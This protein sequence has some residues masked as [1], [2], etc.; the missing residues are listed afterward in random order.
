MNFENLQ[1]RVD[2][3]PKAESIEFEALHKDHKSVQTI[4]ALLFSLILMVIGIC[5]TSFGGY[6]FVVLAWM[7]T[8]TTPVLLFAVLFMLIR[9][10]FKVK[11]YAVRSKD[12]A[13]KSGLIFRVQ[14]LVPYNR[15]QHCELVQGPVEKMF[16]LCHIQ[17]YTAGG[18]DSELRIPGLQHQTGEAL[19]DQLLKQISGNAV[20]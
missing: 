19:R 10:S 18:D 17:I 4:T 16:D 11:G 3:L 7:L 14:T 5:I 9:F 20:N 2:E 15:I 13:Y 8:F 6:V 12:I 1:L